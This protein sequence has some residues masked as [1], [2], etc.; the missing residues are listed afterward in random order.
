MSWFRG[1]NGSELVPIPRLERGPERE[2]AWE[3]G[4]VTAPELEWELV[5]GL[6]LEQE[7]V[8]GLEQE[9]APG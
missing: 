9:L 4:W 8:P 7:L 1:W 3:L 5:L 6:G 2:L